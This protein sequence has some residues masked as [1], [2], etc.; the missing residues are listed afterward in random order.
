M[1]QGLPFTFLKILIAFVRLA[2]VIEFTFLPRSLTL[3]SIVRIMLASVKFSMADHATG[4]VFKVHDSQVLLQVI[5]LVAQVH[6]VK[7]LI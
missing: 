5:R 1:K 3:E 2:L 7:P 6:P 4:T